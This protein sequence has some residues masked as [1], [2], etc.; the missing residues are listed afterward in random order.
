LGVSQVRSEDKMATDLQDG[1]IIVLSFPHFFFNNDKGRGFLLAGG[2]VW[3]EI[4]RLLCPGGGLHSS[5]LDGF[6]E[7]DT[8]G[9]TTG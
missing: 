3:G 7:V 8:P 6:G 4:L 1:D 9:G 2:I 5:P